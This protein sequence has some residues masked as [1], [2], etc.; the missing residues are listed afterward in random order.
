MQYRNG[1]STFQDFNY[2]FYK[3]P[4][5][6]PGEAPMIVLDSKSAMCM[7]NNVKYTKHKMHIAR[8]M[9]LVRNSEK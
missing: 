5:I 3:D 7:N 1:F 8:R 2:F 6:V 9:H 4:Y